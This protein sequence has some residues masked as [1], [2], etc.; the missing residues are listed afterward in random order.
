MVNHATGAGRTVAIT[1]ATGFIGSALAAFLVERG[2]RVLRIGRGPLQPGTTDVAWDISAGTLDAAALEHV[3][4]VVH[5]AGASI[6]TRWTPQHR[7][8]IRDSRV[9]GTTLL[10]KTLA[11]LSHPPRVLV[12]GSAIGIYGSCGDTILDE[13]SAPGNDFL[14]KTGVEWEAAT[15]A[16]SSAGVRV[17]HIRTGIVQDQQGGALAKQLPLFRLGLGGTLG[18]GTQWLSAISMADQVGA[19]LHCI[20]NDH[21]AGAVNVVAP[22]AVTNA[23]FTDI[24]GDLLHRPTLASVPAFAL[25]L[26]LGTEM[27]NLTVLASQRVV[28]RVLLES[29]YAFQHETMRS[30][31][32]S[33][34]G[35]APGSS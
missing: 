25:R 26:A 18:S 34:L 2:Y 5:L 22:N 33:A 8:A 13:S 16:A 23:E 14:A 7:K 35:L 9:L 21:V 4:A 3:H 15:A 19:V 6:A 17:V 29:G 20:E 32:Q 31:L 28:P 1:G 30:I 11:S 10:A 12:S 24:L 27:A